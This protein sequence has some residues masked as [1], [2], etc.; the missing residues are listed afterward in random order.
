MLQ[1]SECHI[2]D[3]YAIIAL[4][5][6]VT[7]VFGPPAETIAAAIARLNANFLKL[8]AESRLYETPC[9]PKGAG[10]DYV[11]AVVKVETSLNQN[12]LL[13]HLNRIEADFD[14]RR[15]GRWASR[16]LDLD[17]VDYGGKI[18]PDHVTQLHW[19]SL[20]IDKQ[21]T[22]SPDKLILPHPRIQDRAFVLI[23][24]ADVAKDW[25]HPATGET[26]QELIGALHPEDVASVKAISKPTLA[27]ASPGE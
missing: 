21:R 6:N 11:N 5:S 15:T 13:A 17:I 8:A 3:T 19:R 20:P 9:F 22:I 14:R 24:L 12:E 2:N 25:V 26:V 1:P 27:K 4:G 23:P 7:S 10:P 18:A 16:T